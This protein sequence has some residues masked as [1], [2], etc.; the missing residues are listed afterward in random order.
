[1]SDTNKK[2]VNITM[3]E[4]LLDELDYMAEKRGMSRSTFL[5][6]LV[7]DEFMK[8]IKEGRLEAWQAWIPE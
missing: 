8:Q 7:S 4:W 6:L 3:S 1:M 2:R 5:S